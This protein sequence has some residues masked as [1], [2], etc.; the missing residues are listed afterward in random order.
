[1]ATPRLAA[2]LFLSTLLSLTRAADPLSI[3][4]WEQLPS[5][6]DPEGFSGSFAGVSHGAL[7]FAGG[8]NFI[9]KRPWENG[10]KLWYDHVYILSSP[11]SQWRLVGQLPRPNAY[12]VTATYGD[13]MICAGGGSLKEHYTEVFALRWNGSELHRRNLP[14]LPHPCAFCCGTIAEDILYVAGG[15][16]RP[17]SGT[18][19]RECWALDVRHPAKGWRSIGPLP[20]PGRMYPVAGAIRDT[21]YV[22][23]GVAIRPN[24]VERPARTFLTDAYAYTPSQGWRRLADLPHADA[25]APSPA[26]VTPSGKLLLQTG[27]DGTRILLDGPNHPGFRKDG[28]LYDP[29]TDRWTPVADGPISRATVPTALWGKS[30]IIPGGERKPGYRS[31]EVWA[32]DLADGKAASRSLNQVPLADGVR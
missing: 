32:V 20:G 4:R 9:G 27:D 19:T 16:P 3:G 5:L 8:S 25:G 26:P 18:A 10:T 30:W 12:G 1:M 17:D 23:S 6:P 7:I 15:I 14:P 29:S 31:N 21:F 2:V 11:Q 28:L 22:L 24:G 13:E